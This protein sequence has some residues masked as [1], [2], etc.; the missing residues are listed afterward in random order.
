[1]SRQSERVKFSVKKNILT[2]IF[3]NDSHSDSDNSTNS[4][5]SEYSKKSSENGSVSSSSSSSSG[6]TKQQSDADKRIDIKDEDL[7]LIQTVIGEFV[8]DVNNKMN[9]YFG[10]LKEINFNNFDELT[11]PKTKNL[12]STAILA[13]YEASKSK[14]VITLCNL[15]GSYCELEAIK[16]EEAKDTVSGIITVEEEAKDT[17]SG[18][19]NVEEEAKDTVSEIINEN[20][21][22]VKMKDDSTHDTEI[23]ILV[24]EMILSIEE[25]KQYSNFSNS[26]DS[27]SPMILLKV[28]EVG[29][30]CLIDKEKYC[31][32]STFSYENYV[33]SIEERVREMTY[34]SKDKGYIYFIYPKGICSKSKCKLSISNH[35]LK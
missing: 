25:G 12:F 30:E 14:I 8:S 26:R 16:E 22:N 19:I 4:N 2:D 3:D 34:E 24:E 1:M 27:S 35:K 23:T 15:L 20:I 5:V 11:K 28:L 18:I 31:L 10:K 33:N 29:Q 17:V 9:I 32:P 6:S 13:P 21:E 7:T